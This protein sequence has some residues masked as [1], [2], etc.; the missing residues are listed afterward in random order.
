MFRFHLIFM[1]ITIHSKLMRQEKIKTRYNKKV[2]DECF[3]F[4]EMFN[5]TK[6]EAQGPWVKVQF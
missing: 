3:Y 5:G 2:F 6:T 4:E 1:P